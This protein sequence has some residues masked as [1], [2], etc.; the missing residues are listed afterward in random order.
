MKP[1]KEWSWWQKY[2]KRAGGGNLLP[3]YPRPKKIQRVN[4]FIVDS[5]AS[6]LSEWRKW[7]LSV[8]AN[9]RRLWSYAVY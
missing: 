7:K 9:R 6:V 4:R 5:Y 2:G 8:E 3:H 1:S